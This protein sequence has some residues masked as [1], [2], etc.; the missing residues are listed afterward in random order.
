MI[1]CCL[2]DYLQCLEEVEMQQF[3]QREC[4]VYNERQLVEVIEK[5]VDTMVLELPL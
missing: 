3:G 5:K 1:P 2:F 4:Y